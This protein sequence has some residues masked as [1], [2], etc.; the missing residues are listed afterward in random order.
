MPVANP[1]FYTGPRDEVTIFS[2]KALREKE[3][4]KIK[5]IHPDTEKERLQKEHVVVYRK[6]P[7][8]EEMSKVY[9]IDFRVLSLIRVLGSRPRPDVRTG[10][11]PGLGFTYSQVVGT[12][13]R[14]CKSGN[15]R[16]KF[17]LQ[18][19]PE[20]QRIYKMM[21]STGRPDRPDE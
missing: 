15:I 9:R 10:K 14:L 12:L 4:R 21:P 8:T 6:I 5:E 11:V 1:L 3:I 18:R 16:A 19:L 17:V 2:K 13:S 7:G 20:L